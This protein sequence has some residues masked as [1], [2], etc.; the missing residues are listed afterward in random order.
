MTQ[1]LYGRIAVFIDG[2]NFIATRN[3]NFPVPLSSISDIADRFFSPNIIKSTWYD[4]KPFF[5]EPD[6][7]P[8]SRS[9]YRAI[10][11]QVKREGPGALHNLKPEQEVHPDLFISFLKSMK[12]RAGFY[13]RQAE[14]LAEAREYFDLVLTENSFVSFHEQCPRCKADISIKTHAEKGEVDRKLSL[15]MIT[16]AYE[17]EYDYALLIAGDRHY[18]DAIEIVQRLGKPVFVSFFCG[19]TS[20]DLIEKADDFISFEEIRQQIESGRSR[21]LE[22]ALVV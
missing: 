9:R 6:I 12:E 3:E 20:Y 17:D 16:G 8:I 18:N 2:P 1:N 22:T 15:D 11:D 13:W 5:V 14:R 7:I 21:N 10:R 19:S 4:S